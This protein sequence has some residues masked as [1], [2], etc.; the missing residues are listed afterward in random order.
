MSGAWSRPPVGRVVQ[1]AQLGALGENL[2]E[3]NG[4]SRRVCRLKK[5][6]GW[7]FKEY[8]KP[9]SA[10][11]VQRLNRLI[12]LPGQMTTTDKVLVDAHTSWPATRVV[13]AQQKTIG[14]LMP[15]APS[16]FSTSRQ[17][18]SGRSEPRMLEVDVLALTE[19][20]QQHIKL[21][22]QS[23]ANR[24]SICA[25]IAAVGALFERQSLVYLDWSYANVFWS[26]GDHSA[27]VIDLDGSSFGPRAQIQSPN[28][29][30]PLV[31]RGHRAGNESDRYRVA[32]L[33]ARC[34][35]GMRANLTETRSG[36]SDLRVRGGAIGEV[37]GLLIRALNAR[38][39]AERPS[40]AEISLAL[41]AA[42]WQALR[43]DVPQISWSG[44]GGVTGWKRV[45]AG[46]STAKTKATVPP[47]PI[48]TSPPI[49]RPTVT[50][51]TTTSPTSIFGRAS[52]P[53]NNTPVRPQNAMPARPTS[54]GGGVIAA[55]LILIL[56]VVLLVIIL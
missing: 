23:L 54:G 29:A 37:A 53:S 17:L 1:Q 47:P 16:S 30:D 26:L 12:Q 14:V 31:P 13:D 56:I 5:Y 20:R 32:L 55:V 38:S 40:I 24:I 48:R 11:G 50:P 9:V 42:K 25:S 19:A 39:T 45:G 18:P 41:E 15:L 52:R 35:T 36:L 51:Q 28:W 43:P 8:P 44:P 2:G 22:P 6:S 21:P 4:E 7:I 33:I 27:Y 34:L 10:P 3:N 49:P 46:N